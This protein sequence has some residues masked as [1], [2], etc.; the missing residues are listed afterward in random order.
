MPVCLNASGRAGSGASA[1]ALRAEGHTAVPF[2]DHVAAVTV[3]GCVDGWVTLH[4]RFG[5]S[6]SAPSSPMP[7]A[8]PPTASRSR[9]LLSAGDP[10]RRAPARRRRLR[11]CPATGSVVRR[12]GVAAALRGIADH[13]RDAFY[14][15]GFG[16]GLLALGDG[17]YTADDLRRRQAD[18]V[19]PLGV[20]AFGHRL[21]TVP[22][23]SQGYLSLAAAWIVDGI[24]VPA[25]VDS[26][27]WFHLL[28]EAA[29]Q[30][31]YDRDDVLS[32]DASGADLLDPARLGPAGVDRRR[33]GGGPGDT[34][35]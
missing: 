22:P 16:D 23:N 17:M 21:W 31:G 35:P 34:R 19:E 27:E 5:G 13:G 4:E 29:K 12:P 6:R 26:P 2:R 25:A 33:P 9:P 3:P 8:T 32:E 10:G 18:W 30:A 11:R 15:G 20:E 28:V 24:G 1:A 7:S 14:L